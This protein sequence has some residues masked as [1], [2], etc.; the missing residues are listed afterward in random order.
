MYVIGERINGM[1]VDIKRA[2]QEK[3]EDPIRSWAERQI[4]AGADA[5]DVNVGPATS[6]QTEALLWMTDIIRRVSADVP[7]AIDNAKWEV[8]QEVIPRVPGPKI[9]NSSKADE[10]A[11]QRYCALA[12]EHGCSLIALTID[13]RGVPADVDSRVMMGATIVTKALEAGLTPD[14]VFIDPIIIPINCA[15]KQPVAVMKALEQL[16]ILSDPPPHLVLGLSNVSQGSAKRELINRTYMAMA[17]AAGLDS[18]IMDPCDKEL[19][20]TAITAEMLMEKM[21]YCD[22]YLEAYRAN[23]RGTPA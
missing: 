18:A 7:L 16:K 20:D 23:R 14:R 6:K 5:L 17:I 2:I 8:M 21:I 4:A 9:I 3:N 19:M 1:F 10:E 22:S 12:A 11:L 15:P 13:A